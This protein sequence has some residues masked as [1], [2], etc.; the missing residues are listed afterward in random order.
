MKEACQKVQDELAAL[1]DG[2]REVVLRHA[3]HL[4]EC[5]ECRDLRHE[6][7]DGPY[8]CHGGRTH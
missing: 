3:D 7:S 6:A 4:A 1:V 5:D 8:R 2:D